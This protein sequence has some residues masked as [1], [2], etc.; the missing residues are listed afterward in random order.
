MNPE[1]RFLP[2]GRCPVR[3]ETRA[4]QKRQ[5]SGYAAVFYRESDPGTQYELWEGFCERI[6]PGAFDRALKEADDC[7]A[8]V[9][10]DPNLV[11]GRTTAGTLRLG[12]DATGLR[13]EID[14]PDTQAGRDACISL[15]RGDMTGSSFSFMPDDVTWR[16]IGDVVIREINS[17]RLYDV[18]PVT[19]PAYAS[20]TAGVRAV[21]DPAEARAA[22]EAYR[23]Q[24]QQEAD[25][26]AH[27]LA[28]YR[29]RA[30]E[31]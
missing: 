3:I 15:E 28:G 18:G 9:N 17:L 26:L 21:G 31:V 24:K 11:L 25:S 8:L 30:A 12:I 10:H 20:T 16:E 27:R 2:A 14:P 29:A 23:T 13:Y 1:R 6:M 19:Y 5:I 7:R 4:D 22:F